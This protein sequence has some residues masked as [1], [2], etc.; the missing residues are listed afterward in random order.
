MATI[1]AILHPSVTGV[2]SERTERTVSMRDGATVRELELTLHVLPGTATVLIDNHM[3]DTDDVLHDGAIVEC[4][5][6]FSGG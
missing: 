2:I 1:T 3:A 4:Y 5:P 6:L